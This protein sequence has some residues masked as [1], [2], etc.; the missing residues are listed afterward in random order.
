[1]TLNEREVLFAT[2]KTFPLIVKFS[3]P[4]IIGMLITSLNIFIDRMFVGNI[5]DGAMA[6]AG[7][8]VSMPVITLIF[9]IAMLAGAGGGAN[10]SLA[11]GRGQRDKARRYMGNASI[12]ALGAS[13]VVS[14]LFFIFCDQILVAFGALPAIL[15]YARE[16]LQVSLLG[17]VIN[18]CGF[19]LNRFVLAM[20]MPSFSMMT[21]LVC[22]GINVVLDPLF[23]FGFGMGVAGAAWATTIAQTGM[24]L[25]LILLLCSKKIDLK[26]AK[27]DFIP[28]MKALRDVVK[29]GMAPAILQLMISGVSL[30]MNHS[31]G[32]YGG[33]EAI[34]AMGI[35]TAVQQVAM[36]PMYGINQGIQPIIGFNFGAQL[37][38]R[39][40]RLLFQGIMAGTVVITVIW[41]AMELFAEPITGLFGAKAY[42]QDLAS[43]GMRVFFLCLPVVGFQVISSNY[44]QAV[45]KPLKSLLLTVSRQALLF[46]PAMIFLPMAFG[47]TGVIAAAP[48]S[49]G[50][51]ALITAFFIGREI[52]KLRHMPGRTEE[53]F[54]RERQ[55]KM[56]VAQA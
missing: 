33:E 2:G 13:A 46:L 40:R 37:Y 19:T 22:V 26:P 49:D 32:T 35:V 10:I 45:G 4:T 53:D 14:L 52:R 28:D 31:L 25:W 51:S 24:L 41:A 36:M 17:A 12:L 29:I 44:F 8:S 1:M 7:I 54:L 18:S 9:A 3:I 20:G 15:P 39:V 38:R 21:N 5:E 16:Y 34:S 55:D 30:T 47:L 23:L 11:L 50:I 56:A 42:I 27:R 6:I 48:V 43:Y